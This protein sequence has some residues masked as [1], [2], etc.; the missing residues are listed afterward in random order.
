MRAANY[1]HGNQLS[2][3]HRGEEFFPALIQACNAAQSE[4]WI[5]T[6]IFALDPTGE[7]VKEALLHAS[8]RG[9]AVHVMVD[10]LGTGREMIARLQPALEAAGIRFVAFNPWFRRGM[11]R[12]HRKI[13]VVDRRIAFLGGL[14]IND[15][16]ISDD[17]SNLPLPAPRWD[18]AVSVSGPLV[19]Q[20]QA[21]VRAQWQRLESRPLRLR[22]ESLR[23][24]V[25]KA[26]PLRA[27]QVA[28]AALV[29]RDNLRNRTTIQRALLQALGRARNSA[30]LVTPYFAPGRKLRKALVH[31]AERGLDVTL[32]IGV[33]QFVMQDA[34]AQSFYPRL[35]RAGVKIVEYRR[36]QL[37]GKVAV[38]DDEWATVGSSNFDG[39]SL[40]VNHEANIIVRDAGFATSLREYIRRGIAEG[41]TITASDVARLSL[42]RRIWNRFAYGLYRFVLQVLTLGSY[43]R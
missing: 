4:I 3:L 21:E 24:Y 1:S 42:P 29:V 28:E 43:T 41:V 5:E 15:D 9:V 10:W 6:Y 26:K 33:G 25:A 12:T 11:V 22:L 7:R 32:L 38:I 34:V 39:L 36:T 27:V 31:A 23:D 18:F 40:F 19:A 30:M 37:H 13:V 35:T 17:G 16:L 8:R 20:V 2:L 14:N